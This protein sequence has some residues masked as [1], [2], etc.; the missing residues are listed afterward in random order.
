M[1]KSILISVGFIFLLAIGFVMSCDKQEM[2][3]EP[4]EQTVIDPVL[5]KILNF[6]DKIENP[7]GVKSDEMISVDSAVWYIEAALNYT[8]CI[9]PDTTLKYTGTT[10]DSVFRQ[11]PITDGEVSFNEVQ[12]AYL[13]IE[14]NIL[15]ALNKLPGDN[16]RVEVVDVF[17]KDDE[18]AT[19]F[20]LK[21]GEEEGK[22]GVRPPIINGDWH[23]GGIFVNGVLIPQGMCDNTYYGT[24]D[25]GTEINRVLQYV[26]PVS[27]YTYFTD[28]QMIEK[29]HFTQDP[30]WYL[31]VRT[32]NP[33]D[34]WIPSGQGGNPAANL[35][36]FWFGWAD[37]YP[38][39]EYPCISETELRWYKNAASHA[40]TQIK[41]NLIPAGYTYKNCYFYG[42][43]GHNGGYNPSQSYY[44]H[45][46][47]VYYGIGHVVIYN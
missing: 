29:R 9:V 2:N 6:K 34:Y 18:F 19:Y 36:D 24:R 15:A 14:S 44:Y 3:Q 37:Y 30:D 42:H 35:S 40:L 1:K 10:I 33:Y 17:F 31:F 16:K 25:A 47:E 32:D 7:D 39:Y 13:S 22:G 5:M 11:I 38:N 27:Q 21:Y 41:N 4:T 8:Y 20:M 23:W 46:L 45:A 43:D 28:V 26:Q 12:I